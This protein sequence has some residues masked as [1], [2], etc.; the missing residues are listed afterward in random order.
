MR[1]IDKIDFIAEKG[2]K[3][4]YMQ[5]AYLLTD[6]NTIL[7]EFGNLLKIPDNYPKYVVSMDPIIKPKD[8]DGITPVSSSMS[9]V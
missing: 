7:R 5:V 4:I 9:D 3:T 6:N 2:G 1:I 8:Y